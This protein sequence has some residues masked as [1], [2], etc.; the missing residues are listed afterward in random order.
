MPTQTTLAAT[1]ATA[2]GRERIV[3]AAL[4]ML[5]V[6]GEEAFSMRRLATQ[7]DC[8]PM[9]LYNHVAS[10]EDLYAAAV[11]LALAEVDVDGLGRR[12]DTQLVELARR[13]RRA[14]LVHPGVTGLMSRGVRI[15][16]S[17][18]RLQE[19]LLTILLDAGL[20]PADVPMALLTFVAL[21]TSPT[22]NGGLDTVPRWLERTSLDDLDA[23]AYPKTR[24]LAPALGAADADDAFEFAIR[25]YVD[26]LRRAA[27]RRSR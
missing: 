4:A 25:G 9:S 21:T 6:D 23:D 14:L 11:D 15:G 1:R 22:F 8:A 27:G 19:R 17:T 2:L 7:L 5:D 24:R 18:L 16:P 26:G 3:A 12:W 20:R 13:C 10:K